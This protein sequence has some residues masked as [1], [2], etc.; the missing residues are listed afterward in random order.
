MKENKVSVD[1]DS[2][3]D[4]LDV[5]IL[6]SKLVDDGFDV[7]IVTSRQCTERALA[8][9]HHWVKRQ[10]ESLYTVA[11]SCGIKRENIIFTEFIDKI[12][13]LKDKGFL[14]HLDDDEDEIEQILNSGDSCIGINV[15]DDK[16]LE[17]INQII[18]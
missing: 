7:Y 9:G 14:F 16:W 11:D 5:Q 13:F 4:R 12:V 3:L 17:K 8:M 6:A 2:T 18:S 1:F 15:E 10:N